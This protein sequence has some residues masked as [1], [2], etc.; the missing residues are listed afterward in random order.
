MIPSSPPKKGGH[1]PHDS[2]FCSPLPAPFLRFICLF[3]GEHHHRRSVCEGR[4]GHLGALLSTHGGGCGGADE[5]GAQAAGEEFPFRL[6]PPTLPTYLGTRL[7]GLARAHRCRRL[8]SFI[9]FS[10]LHR[11]FSPPPPSFFFPRDARRHKVNEFGNGET[12][13]DISPGETRRGQAGR[14]D[15]H[16]FCVRRSDVAVGSC[17]SQNF[18]EAKT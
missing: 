3:Y 5:D 14:R 4:K 17:L 1:T 11:L 6:T 10:H 9:P 2:C 8:F 18:Q 13:G 16:M 7:V 12:R 15:A